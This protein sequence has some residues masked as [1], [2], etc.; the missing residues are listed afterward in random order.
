MMAWPRN[1]PRDSRMIFYTFGPDAMVARHVLHRG[2]DVL[3]HF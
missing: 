2:M 1:G 3:R